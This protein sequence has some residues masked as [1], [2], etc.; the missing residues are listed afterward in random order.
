MQGTAVRGSRNRIK[1]QSC[2]NAEIWRG[3]IMS[4]T[5]MT[6]SM[7]HWWGEEKIRCFRVDS[8]LLREKEKKNTTNTHGQKKRD[9][10]IGLKKRPGSS[11]SVTGAPC[12]RCRLIGVIA[13]WVGH[14]V[15]GINFHQHH[16]PPHRAPGKK[17]RE[18]ELKWRVFYFSQDESRGELLLPE[19]KHSKVCMCVWVCVHARVFLSLFC[20]GGGINVL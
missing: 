2:V 3:Y 14:Q 15:V 20:F 18:N 4:L 10:K 7:C 13:P 6:N 9:A 5:S 11:G 12:G 17:R 16:M 19:H 8:M 1:P